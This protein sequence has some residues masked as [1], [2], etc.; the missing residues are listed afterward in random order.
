MIK[1]N[2]QYSLYT[3]IILFC[4]LFFNSSLLVLAQS[5]YQIG[6]LPSLTLTKKIN[7]NWKISVNAQTRLSAYKG[8]FSNSETFQEN[9]T[10]ILTD[11]SVLANRKLG[12]NTSL[13]AGYLIR[14]RDN[15]QHN[16]IFQQFIISKKYNSFGLAHRFSTDQT[17][18]LNQKVEFRLRYRLAFDLPLQGNKLNPNELYVKIQNEYLIALQNKEYTN[19]TRIM[20]FL[21]YAITDK[22]KIELGI[23]YRIG[24]LGE[25]NLKSNFWCALN[26]YWSF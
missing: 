17:F 8:E 12:L 4:I 22:K 18:R 23:D 21:G 26:Y 10:Y 13:A 9:F 6:I 16:R 2:I 3:K 19:E 15:E 20:P 1:K 5:T 25:K 11:V 24:S 7:P 14:F